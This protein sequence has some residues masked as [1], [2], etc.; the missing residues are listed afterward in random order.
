MMARGVG[1]P[2][3]HP[4]PSLVILTPM[5]CTCPYMQHHTH[6]GIDRHVTW[7]LYALQPGTLEIH[8][9]DPLQMDYSVDRFFDSVCLEDLF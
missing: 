4:I 7:N 8:V 9:K 1:P 6:T 2:N 5:R 3:A